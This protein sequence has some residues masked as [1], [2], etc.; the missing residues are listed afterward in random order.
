MA[1]NKGTTCGVLP[2]VEMRSALFGRF[3]VSLPFVNYGGILADTP[4]CEAA[5]AAAAVE[6]AAATKAHHVELRQSFAAANCREAG[7]K[8]RRHKAALVVR[9]KTDPAAHW[10]ELSSRLRGKVRK[11]EKSGAAFSVER[12]EALSD[13]YRVFSLNMRDLGTPVYS[14]AFFHNIFHF[15]K[16]A[17]V[18]LVR[19]AGRPVAAAIALRRAESVELPWICSDYSQSSFN[20]NEFLYWS[21]IQW[22]CQ[23]G[24]KELDLGRSS[25]DA[26]TYRIKI[27]WNPEVRPMYW[28][29]W[30]AAG[31]TP[32][33]LN[34]N[35]P[36]YALAIRC[37]KKLPVS[38]ANRFGPWI[39]RN[40]P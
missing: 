25:V 3:L 10:S 21:A 8:L 32:P 35:N 1:Q 4:E 11:A 38:L 9:L 2:L 6:L 36:K 27:Q 31:A 22:G 12:S 30:L 20:V 26:G 39:V 16:D 19:R 34:P 23:S 24:A 17:A 28:Y 15:A 37:W 40:I 33:E 13:F 7:W 29:Y 18:L 14:P 5:L